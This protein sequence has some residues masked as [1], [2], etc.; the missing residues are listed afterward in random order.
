VFG[1]R[2]GR[3]TPEELAEVARVY[4]EAYAAGRPPKKAV[5][6]HFGLSDVGASKRIRLARDGG[7]LGEARGRGA[8]GEA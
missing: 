6:S 8:P 2:R 3:L 7:Y 5:V 1:A 4:R